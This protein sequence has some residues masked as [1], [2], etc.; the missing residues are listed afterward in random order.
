MRRS[1]K[2]RSKRVDASVC[3]A[4]IASGV[5]VTSK[6]MASRR[7]SST[8]R[9][10]T[11]SST[12]RTRRF[13]VGLAPAALL[14]EIDPLQVLQI[15]AQGL[16]ILLDAPQLGLARAEL[17]P[18][19]ADVVTGGQQVAQNVAGGQRPRGGRVVGIARQQLVV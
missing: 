5:D 19:P 13:M 15:P 3:R 8:S 10:A 17:L 4:R 9:M 16:Q 11:S 12:I 2:A 1:S 18:Q 14:L 6:P 7:I